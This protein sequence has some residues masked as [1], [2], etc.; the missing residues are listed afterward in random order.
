MTVETQLERP[1]RREVSLGGLG[2]ARGPGKGQ[3]GPGRPSGR[4]GA[5][6]GGARRVETARGRR[7]ALGAVRGRVWSRTMS[8]GRSSTRVRVDLPWLQVA[9]DRE[10]ERHRESG[11]AVEVVRSDGDGSRG[12]GEGQALAVVQLVVDVVGVLVALGGIAVALGLLG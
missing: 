8:A 12:G 1:S 10:R 5:R 3:G 11:F 6:S 2:G 7:R 4:S 9:H